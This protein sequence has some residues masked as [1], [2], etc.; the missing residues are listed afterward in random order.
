MLAVGV[1]AIANAASTKIRVGNLILTFGGSISPSKL[2]KNQYAPVTS[3]IFGKIQT[4]DGTHPPAFREAVVDITNV[5]VDTKGIP[6]CKA[7]QLQA[8]DTKA[9]KRVCGKTEIGSGEAH[10][11]IA[12]PEQRPIVVPSPITVFNGGTKGGKTKM[13]IHTFI[14]VPVPAAI[15]T[16][17][18]IKKKG[19][20]INAV[21]K[22]PV[23]AGG[24]G[25]ALDFKFKV[26]KKVVSAKCPSGS[27]KASTTK[28]VF[29][30]EA[31]TPGQPAQVIAKG[32]VLVPCKPKG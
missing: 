27:I 10:A 23:I 3:N 20:G 24:S 30:N 22:V 2:P 21:A 15:V 31:G 14:T 12:F 5:K 32:S 6:V 29:K 19:S 8:R 11:E 1:A 16:D 18:T 26:S 13:L 9:A 7:S 4:S 25:S 17:V 28:T